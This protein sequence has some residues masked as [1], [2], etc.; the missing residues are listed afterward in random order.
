MDHKESPQE[1]IKPIIE[2]FFSGQVQEA[3][4]AVETLTKSYPNDS[5]LYNIS[6][7]CYAGL[8]K[9]DTAAAHAI[10]N[11][12][13]GSFYKYKDQGDHCYNKENLLNDWFV[14]ESNK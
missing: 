8:G 12:S 9:L 2:L 10:V 6:G 1:L 5:L 3:L 11:E 14:V 7:A 13:D 4:D